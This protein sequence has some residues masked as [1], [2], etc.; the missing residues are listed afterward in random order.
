MPVAELAKPRIY[1]IVTP[2]MPEKTLK[3]AVMPGDGIG[4]EVVAE[5]L[6][7]LKVAA[8]KFGFNYETTDY[9]FGA[10][11]YLKTKVTLPDSAVKELAAHDAI[12]FGAVG[13]DPRGNA[14]IPQG[15]IETDILLKMR[16]ELDQ[17]INLRPT[18][19]LPGVP[20]PLANVQVGDIDMVIV[21]ENTEGLYCQNG[22][23][24]YKGTK[25]EVANQIEV[26]TRHGVERAIRY[27]FEY[28]KQFNRKKVTLVAKTNVLRFAHNL[29]QRAFEEVKAEFPGIETDYHHVDA[30]TM[31][32]VTRPKVYDVIVTTNMFGDIITDLGAAIQGG[33]GMA[34]S[35]NINPTR[36]AASMF[37]PVHGSA[38]DIAGKNYA[39]PIATFLS[40]AMMLDFL[41]QPKAANAINQAC[42]DVVAD[43]KNHTRD[44]GGTATTTQ[45]GEAVCK[46]LSS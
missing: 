22:G 21:R 4:K 12:L 45:V 3:I 2:P 43:R 15:L 42:K 19:L 13:A 5:G 20:T 39:N 33:M 41:N 25:H 40:V 16:F 38:P 11:H 23:F 28:A 7:V 1:Y 30:C 18:R 26:A 14:Q 35:G 8:G 34:A 46:L 32:M 31:Y 36:Q 17:Y 6:R 27:A 37:E 10:E 24:L 9:P 29:W 44:L